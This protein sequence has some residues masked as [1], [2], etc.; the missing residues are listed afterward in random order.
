MSQMI[1]AEDLSPANVSAVLAR[2]AAEVAK[3]AGAD[4][5]EVAGRRIGHLMILDHLPRWKMTG[6]RVAR[7]TPLYSLLDIG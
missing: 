2:I 4:E 1:G 5:V 7:C 6:R 3:I